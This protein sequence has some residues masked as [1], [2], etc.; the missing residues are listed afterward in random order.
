VTWPNGF[1]SAGPTAGRALV[2][3]SAV[4]ALL[5]LAC[6]D[7]AAD[8][9]VQVKTGVPFNPASITVAQGDSAVLGFT[10]P[11]ARAGDRVS[12]SSS[13]PTVAEPAVAEL[14]PIGG[15]YVRGKR[16]GTATL[17]VTLFLGGQ[18]IVAAVPVT[19][20][21]RPIVDEFL[22]VSPSQRTLAVG[23]TARLTAT[24]STSY[25]GQDAGVTFAS[26]DTAV[27]TVDAAGL[28]TGRRVG[29][30][31]VRVASRANANRVTAATITVV[32]PGFGDARIRV[33]P[34]LVTLAPNAD[35][36]L[37]ASLVR[38]DSVLTRDSGAFTFTSSDSCVAYVTGEGRVVGGRSG[39]AVVTVAS[40][41]VPTQSAAVRTTVRSPGPLRVTIQSLTTGSPRQPVD[42]GAVRGTITVGV[43][44]DAS[45]FPGRVELRLGGRLVEARTLPAAAGLQFLAF[46]VNTAARD[47]VTGAPLYPNGL[48][49]IEISV[50]S[51]R[52]PA[53]AGCPAELDG[54]TVRLDVTLAN[55][56]TAARRVP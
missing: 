32:P 36:T 2:A 55:P 13:D 15:V 9:V 38:G 52:A 21:P 56:T 42:L 37:A 54:Q 39:E 53:V 6:G 47:A 10:F 24:F 31:T 45:L 48:R 1:R 26:L 19:V 28:V 29:V 25:P 34:A 30:A 41:D 43:N 4:A 3:A 16:A 35:V 40:R 46:E 18:T 50:A 49:A 8:P 14:S 33:V 7:G 23:D 5:A 11:A 51:T 20:T 44:V 22:M 27:A 12:I 17:T